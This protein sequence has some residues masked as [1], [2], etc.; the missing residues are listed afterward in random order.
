MNDLKILITSQ[1]FYPENFRINS[2]A[3]SLVDMGYD[4]D[5]ITGIPN[6]P[7][8]KV[9]QG[10][11]KSSLKFES[12]KGINVFRVPIFLRGSAS[13]LSL[14]LNYLSFIFSACFFGIWKLKKKYDVIFCYGTSPILQAIPAILLAKKNQAPLL[15]N[16]Q[17]LWPESV[18]AT[19]RIHSPFVIKLLAKIVS[20]IYKRANVLLVQSEAFWEPILKLNSEANIVYWPNSIDPIFY[21][22]QSKEMPPSLAAIFSENVFTVTFAGNIGSAQSIKT[23][24]QAAYLL[25]AE[26]RIKIVLLGDGGMREWAL[27]QKIKQEMNNLFIPG[28]FSEDL[29][30]SV[31]Q[32]SSCLLVALTN[33]SIFN[34]TIPNKIQGYLALG[35]PIIGSLDGASAN[36]IMDADAGLVAPAENSQILAITILKMSKMKNDDLEAYGLN[37]RRYFMKYFEH[38]Q[39]MKKLNIIIRDS[40]QL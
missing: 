40:I 38:D 13:N 3:K 20:W 14:T 5:V 27:Q 37:G 19:D 34:L 29:M 2:V 18:S 8:G 22:G 12:Y 32:K 23:I 36:I 11:S 4:V 35:R 33:R 7:S 17:D 15:L 31:Y 28:S 25:K 1:H 39:L 16:V 10:Y 21:S 30:P 24:V 26:T 6:Y 9:F